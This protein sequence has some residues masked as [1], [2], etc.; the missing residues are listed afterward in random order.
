MKRPYRYSHTHT[1]PQVNCWMDF[2]LICSFDW[3]SQSII[4]HLFMYVHT[5]FVVYPFTQLA[6]DRGFGI[7]EDERAVVADGRK[8]YTFHLCGN[9]HC[10]KWKYTR[11][12]LCSSL[13]S[14]A[15]SFLFTIC[16]FIL[17][18]LVFLCHSSSKLSPDDE[19][20]K[21][22]QYEISLNWSFFSS[23]NFR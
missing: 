6:V 4:N 15:K 21:L 23:S 14:C 3:L 2:L 7:G 10:V 19:M 12:I 11:L 9:Q 17:L 8:R 5:M 13:Y 22:I 1:N 16:V 20:W 18:L